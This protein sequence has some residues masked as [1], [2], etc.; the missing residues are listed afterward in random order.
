MDIEAAATAFV[1]RIMTGVPRDAEALIALSEEVM[2]A[3]AVPLEALDDFRHR[4][5]ELV[6]ARL[7]LP[8]FTQT[9]Q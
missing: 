3:H 8:R 5:G 1:D 2:T 6:C 4:A 9:L 7:N